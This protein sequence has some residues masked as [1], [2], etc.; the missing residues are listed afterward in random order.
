[1]PDFDSFLFFSKCEDG[2]W[3]CTDRVCPGLCAAW[4]EGH[5]K[6]FDDKMYDFSG[7]CDYVLAKG[8]MSDTDSFSVN[9]KNVPCGTSTVTCSKAATIKIG[10]GADQEKLN[11][12]RGK[13]VILGPEHKR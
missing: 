10:S 7:N 6:T 9:I 5:F 2:M 8:H 13:D 4:G 12:V 1:M 3:S 11:I